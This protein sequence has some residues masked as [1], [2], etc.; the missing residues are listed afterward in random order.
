MIELEARDGV[1]WLSLA[2]PAA[3]NALNRELTA[4]LED[5]LDR[6]AAMND[7]SVL[8]VRGRGRAFCAGNDIAE[9]A[10]LS[11]EEAEALASRQARLMTRF[12]EL[13]QVTI[14]AV[15]G[16]ALGGGLM[17]ALAQ[18]LRIA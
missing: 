6:V 4:A 5:G 10:T 1:A 9:M 14:A 13:P 7:V 2:R 17:L 3:L 12:A 16:H 18:D 15:D 11:G 8:V